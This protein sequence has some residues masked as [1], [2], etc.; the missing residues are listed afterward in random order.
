MPGN[1][2][3]IFK[4]PHGSHLYNLAHEN[5]DEDW[6]TVIDYRNN[7]ARYAKQK[8]FGVE[9]SLV[10]NMGTFMLYAEKGVPQY[11]EAMFSQLATVDHIKYM[12]EQFRPDTAKAYQTYVRTIRAFYEQDDFKHRRHA[13]RLAF[14]LR[15]LLIVGRFDPT[16]DDDK[17]R[18]LNSEADSITLEEIER[19]YHV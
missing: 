13:M 2:E 4:T 7:K 8:I 15:D 1:K 19:I 6:F 9:D 5:S 3:T 11:L 14:N 16:L 10:T 17:V 12:R 18:I